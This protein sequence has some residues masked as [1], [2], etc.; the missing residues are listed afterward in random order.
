MVASREP[1]RTTREAPAAPRTAALRCARSPSTTT[2][3]ASAKH[4]SASSASPWLLRSPSSSGPT[5]ARA[6]SSTARS[7]TGRDPACELPLHDENVSWRHARVEDRGNGDWALVDLGSTNGTM[8]DGKPCR[9]RDPRCPAIASSS[10]RPSSR[11]RRTPLRDAQAAEL[12]RLLLDRRSQ[13]ASGFAGASTRSS[14]RASRRSLAGTVPALSVVVMDMDGVKAIND[15]HGHALGAFAIGADG[16]TSSAASSDGAGFAT[17]FGGDE[18]AAAFPA[19]PKDGALGRRRDARGR[20]R[21]RLRVPGQRPLHPGLSCGVASIPGDAARR[22]R[23][24]SRP[25]TRPCTGPSAPARTASRPEAEPSRAPR[26]R[27]FRRRARDTLAGPMLKVECESCK[28]PYQIDERRVPPAGLKM[29]CPKCGHSFLVTNPAGARLRRPG[30]RREAAAPPPGPA[31]P[32]AACSAVRD[33]AHDGR[34]RAPAPPAQ[35][36]GRCPAPLRRL[37]RPSCRP[38]LRPP[39]PARSPAPPAAPAP[40]PPP[41]PPMRGTLPPTS[42]GP[43]V[44]RRVGPARRSRRVFPRVRRPPR[45]PRPLLRPRRSPRRRL[46]RPPRGSARSIPDLPVVAA[47]L[48]TAKAA[49][50]SSAAMRGRRSTSICRCA[51]AI[52]RRRSAA[53]ICWTCPSSRRICPPP[54]VGLPA[55]AG[56]LP[57]PAAS[58]PVA[59]GAPARRAPRACRASPPPAGRRRQPAARSRPSCPGRRVASACPPRRCPSRGLRRD[60]AARRADGQAAPSRSSEAAGAV[61]AVRRDRPS[62][63]GR[64]RD[65]RTPRTSATSSSRTS[66][67]PPAR[68]A[69]PGALRSLGERPQPRRRTHPRCAGDGGSLRR[70]RL[71]R[72]RRR[73]ARSVRSASTSAP[74]GERGRPDAGSRRGDG[75]GVTSV[76]SGGRATRRPALLPAKRSIG[77]LVAGG[78]LARC[79]AGRRRRAPAHAATARSGTSPSATP[80]TPGDYAARDHGGGHADA[81]KALRRDTY[82]AAQGGRRRVVA[83]HARVAAGDDRST[84]YAAFVDARRPSRFGDGPG[85]HA[86][87]KHL[88]RRAAAGRAPCSTSDVAAAAQAAA[89]GDLDKARKALDAGEPAQAAGDPIQLDVALLRGERRARGAR[90]AG[91]RSRRSS[92]RSRSSARRA[93][94]TSGWRGPTTSRRRGRAHEGDR[95]DAGRS[96]RSTRARSRC[97]RA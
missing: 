63:R 39:V 6:S 60:R 45:S 56:D 80:C 54:S 47:D 12:E 20:R 22:R 69:Q 19:L 66:R 37:P 30:A 68:R 48:P 50:R 14:R 83:A 55:L 82:D 31:A 81:D 62:H 8:L 21:A 65:G 72:R 88:A 86:A 15:T 26:G 4:S 59:R 3:T 92:T 24:S 79:V 58:L 74:P 10:A 27:G 61:R 43:R 75:R 29:R 84:A 90:R 13:R 53:T 2:R 89:D 41:L 9:G 67:D 36:S 18:F 7:D 94:R 57:V 5:W 32:P 49:P 51:R 97:A 95:C 38:G 87:A 42:R 96:R 78:V 35:P 73:G 1:C 76:R 44:A 40:A 71:R 16:R 33:E 46:R 93:R 34:R 11:C 70:G 17:R 23:P 77:K 52:R 91:G 85:A 28:A 64:R 25:P